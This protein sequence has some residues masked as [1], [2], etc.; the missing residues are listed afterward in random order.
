VSKDN[1]DLATKKQRPLKV[2]V[3][4]RRRELCDTILRNFEVARLNLRDTQ[5]SPEAALIGFYEGVTLSISPQDHN[6]NAQ[7]SFDSDGLDLE[8]ALGRLQNAGKLVEYADS[9]AMVKS[10]L[11]CKE[12]L[13]GF[14]A[15]G[16]SARFN[17]VVIKHRQAEARYTDDRNG[18]FSAE[19]F[20]DLNEILAEYDALDLELQQ[21]RLS[22]AKQE[23]IGVRIATLCGRISCLCSQLQ[24][25]QD[26]GIS[27]AIP[28]L[29]AKII[30]TEKQV[31]NLLASSREKGTVAEELSLIEFSVR[32]SLQ[33]LTGN[34]RRPQTE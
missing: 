22:S 4:N 1:D 24:I 21:S 29:T 25:A 8:N 30:A 3:A 19:G 12:S 15:V 31:E 34:V 17:S 10:G 9:L 13:K 16:F 7:S 23:L 27:P 32:A 11:S 18:K 14:W 5:V 6:R 33:R 28:D 26:Q 20:R 2:E